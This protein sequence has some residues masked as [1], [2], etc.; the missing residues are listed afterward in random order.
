MSE[1]AA[2]GTMHWPMPFMKPYNTK[3]ISIESAK[4]VK[5]TLVEKRSVPITITHLRRKKSAAIPANGTMQP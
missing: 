5:N 3:N 1:L 2:P 4:P